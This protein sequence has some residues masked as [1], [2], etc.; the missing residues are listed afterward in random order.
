M[1]GYV[2]LLVGL[3]NP[4]SRYLLNRHNVGFILIDALAYYYD[5]PSFKTKF[6]GLITTLTIDKV[7]CLLLKP[8]TYMNLSGEC[9]RAVMSFYKITKK[10]EIII[11]ANDILTE[12]EISRIKKYYINY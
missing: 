10:T 12:E 9:V 6:N 11:T 8:S 1:E 2:R 7:D 4:E 5:A 3:G